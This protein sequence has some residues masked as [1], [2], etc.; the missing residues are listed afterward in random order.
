MSRHIEFLE[1]NMLI[2]SIY[3]RMKENHL[4]Q[5]LVLMRFKYKN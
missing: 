2:N 3:N 4:P 5:H 1:C